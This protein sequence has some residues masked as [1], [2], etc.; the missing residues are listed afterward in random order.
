MAVPGVD[1]IDPDDHELQELAAEDRWRRQRQAELSRHPDC[2]DDAHPGCAKCEPD[3][4]D[5]TTANEA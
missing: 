3:E 2:R 1:V 5:D 4:D